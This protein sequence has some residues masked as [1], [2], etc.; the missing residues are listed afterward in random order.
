MTESAKDGEEILRRST[1]LITYKWYMKYT[2]SIYTQRYIWYSFSAVTQMKASVQGWCGSPMVYSISEALL[3]L[4]A[5]RAHGPNSQ[6]HLVV[7]GSHCSPFIT[8]TF[9]VQSKKKEAQE[10]YLELSMPPAQDRGLYLTNTSIQRETGTYF[11]TGL[12]VIHWYQS[13]FNEKKKGQVD[14]EWATHNFCHNSF[15]IKL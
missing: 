2:Y 10:R 11:L 4:S 5:C 15:N 9:Q 7:T 14:I 8:S 13:S 1:G 3:S 12:M 6:S